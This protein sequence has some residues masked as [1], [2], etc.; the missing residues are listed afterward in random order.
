MSRPIKT[1]HQPDFH[2]LETPFGYQQTNPFLIKQARRMATE[3]SESQ[4]I[5]IPQPYIFQ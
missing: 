3:Q 1:N 4:S 5:G 2:I